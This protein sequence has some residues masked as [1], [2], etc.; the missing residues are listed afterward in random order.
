MLGRR[1]VNGAKII[2]YK[3]TVSFYV[4]NILAETDRVPLFVRQ[5][6]FKR[7]ASRCGH[8]RTA[9][10]GASS[11]LHKSGQAAFWLA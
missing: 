6:D 9:A 2:S 3:H 7:F 1:I 11:E 10:Q 4:K 8:T 5:V